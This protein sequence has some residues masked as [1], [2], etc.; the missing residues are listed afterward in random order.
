MRQHCDTTNLI[1][2]LLQFQFNKKW[3]TQN[4]QTHDP[5]T[6]K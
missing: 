4:V 1:G 6:T 5:M 3:I 2:L